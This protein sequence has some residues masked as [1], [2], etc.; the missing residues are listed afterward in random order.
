MVMCTASAIRVPRDESSN[1][2]TTPPRH[3]SFTERPR[4]IREAAQREAN[5]DPWEPALQKLHGRVG[6]IGPYGVERV[7]TQAAFDQLGVP[8]GL[9]P[10]L[11]GYRK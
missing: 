8:M 4:Q 11:T 5:T 3:L 2:N 6:P 9:R 10:T 7:T 1:H